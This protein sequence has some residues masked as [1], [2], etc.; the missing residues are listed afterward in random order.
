M[1]LTS[2]YQYSDVTV[3]ICKQ[4]D[5]ANDLTHLKT[6]QSFRERDNYVEFV[7]H[8]KLESGTYWIFAKIDWD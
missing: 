6:T 5:S 3:T 4:G 2:S 7:D 8:E 1:P